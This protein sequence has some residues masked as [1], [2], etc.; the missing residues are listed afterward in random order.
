MP[1]LHSHTHCHV[2]QAKAQTKTWQRVCVSHR[3][4]DRQSGRKTEGQLTA[5]WRNGGCSASYEHLW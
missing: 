3:A 2:S 1:T 4:T 5:V